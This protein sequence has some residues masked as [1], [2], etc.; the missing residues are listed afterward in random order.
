M[1]A[2]KL[3]EAPACEICFDTPLGPMTATLSDVGIVRLAFDRHASG[4][5]G[6]PHQGILG[7]LAKRLHAYAG[8]KRVDFDDFE[9]DMAGLTPFRRAVT[10]ACRRVAYGEVISYRELARRAGHPDAARAVGQVMATNRWPIIVP[11]HRIIA[12]GGRLG[13]YSAPEGPMLKKRLLA[14]E[15]GTRWEQKL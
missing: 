3:L 6:R 5:S 2:S 12:S 10:E 9:L 13:G 8:G 7:K 15:Q 14:L 4:L 11:C 1:A